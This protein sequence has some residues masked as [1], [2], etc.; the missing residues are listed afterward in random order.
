MIRGLLESNGIP[1]VVQSEGITGKYMEVGLLEHGRRRLTGR[2]WIHAD[3]LDEARALLDA[4]VSE[5]ED[6]VS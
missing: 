4:A 6:E 2:S 3:R 1:S 5:D